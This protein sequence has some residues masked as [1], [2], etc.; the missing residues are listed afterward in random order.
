[1]KQNNIYQVACCPR[2]LRMKACLQL[3]GPS[4]LHFTCEDMEERWRAHERE[5]QWR[6][7]SSG[8]WGSEQEREE[9]EKPSPFLV[10]S[11]QHG[12]R[13]QAMGCTGGKCSLQ[14]P[15]A[16]VREK[17]CFQQ[18]HR[19]FGKLSTPWYWFSLHL[20]LN[21]FTSYL[22]TKFYL[23]W[24]CSA[25]NLDKCA[26]F[27]LFSNHC[28]PFQRNQF[29]KNFHLQELKKKEILS[30]GPQATKYPDHVHL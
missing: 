27:S 14:N 20:L 19:L 24:L 18:P 1:M 3:L 13:P 28:E 23:L 8:R 17:Q 25:W 26:S 5:S 6:A 4:S 11:N 30:S 29:L 12:N 21:H 2:C 10:L 22:W 15:D 16:K 7:S 9:S